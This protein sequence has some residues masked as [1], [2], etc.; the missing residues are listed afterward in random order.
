MTETPLP[1]GYKIYPEKDGARF[2]TP[3]TFGW[4]KYVSICLK[5][6]TREIQTGEPSWRIPFG[7]QKRALKRQ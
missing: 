1:R 6:I 5:E 2:E 4:C 7:K 3:T